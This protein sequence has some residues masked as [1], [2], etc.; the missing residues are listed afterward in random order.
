MVVIS[1]YLRR[2][3]YTTTALVVAGLLGL[4]ALFDLIGELD[5]MGEG[6]YRL[7]DMFVFV[8][9]NMPGHLYEILP[10]A[11]LIGTTF[12]LTQMAQQ[13]EYTVIRASGVSALRMALVL[14]RAGVTIALVGVL[15]GE[16][17]APAAERTAQALRLQAKAAAVAQAFR[18]GLWVKDGNSFINVAQVTPE[19]RL[20]GVRVYEFDTAWR[21]DRV[22]FAERGAYLGDNRWNMEGV[23][24]TRFDGERTVVVHAPARE[25]TSVLT[26]A[27]LTVLLVKPEAMSAAGLWQYVQHLRGSRQAASRYEIALWRKA[28]YPLAIVVMLV[29][30]LPFAQQARRASAGPRVF[31]SIMLGLAFFFLNTLA[32]H[33]GWLY[34]WPAPLAALLAP[35]AFLCIAVGLVAYFERR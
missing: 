10:V 31:A 14:V 8:M 22:W 11:A 12:V 19:P 33:A 34:D 29:L 18:S 21:L 23:S 24:E 16:A 3:V 27:L 25:W 2:E 20:V 6:S 13:S 26:P 7:R 1:R 17:V 4:F 5:D 30:A 35:L 15:V 32:S 28:A 9:L